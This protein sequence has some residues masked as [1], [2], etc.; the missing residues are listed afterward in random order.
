MA[1]TLAK[2]SLNTGNAKCRKAYANPRQGAR[3]NQLAYV[4]G[5]MDG[6]GTITIARNISKKHPGKPYYRIYVTIS[7]TD[8]EVL[9][10]IQ[11]WFP[12]G[13]ILETNDKRA[14]PHYRQAYR[15]HTEGPR[16]Y[17]M[18][19]LLKPYLVI[20]RKQ[21]ALALGFYWSQFIKGEKKRLGRNGLT[22]DILQTREKF[23]WKMRQLNKSDGLGRPR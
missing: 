7:S 22:D 19:I 13:K 3:Q 11:T 23:Y 8:L 15:Y 17:R 20:K 2:S 4:A 1:N 9:Q 21:A 16:A 12:E 10:L 18:L 6:E 5:F 14:K